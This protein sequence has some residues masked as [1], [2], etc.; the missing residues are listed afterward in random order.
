MTAFRKWRRESWYPSAPVS[1]ADVTANF[2]RFVDALAA[3]PKHDLLRNSHFARQTRW[4]RCDVVDYTHIYEISELDTE[5]RSDLG[6]HLRAQGETK[7]VTLRRTNDTP[8]VANRQAVPGPVCRKIERLYADDFAAFGDRWDIAKI[9]NAPE[10]SAAALIDVNARIVAGDRVH[11]ILIELRSARRRAETAIAERDAL[12]QQL[13]EA[14][15]LRARLERLSRRH[16][17]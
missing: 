3:H 2:A 11:E 14:T 5:F 6:T 15:S 16:R 9:D 12:A 17:S 4:L 7:P 8:L 13:R 10:W 1:A